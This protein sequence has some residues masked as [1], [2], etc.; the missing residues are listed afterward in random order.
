MPEYL[1]TFNIDADGFEAVGGVT[2]S[3]VIVWV[4]FI[5]LPQSSVTLYVLVITSGQVLPSET[6]ETKATTG[7]TVQLSKASVT[8]VIS[9]AGISA[10]HSTCIADGFEA[11]GGVTSSTVIVWVTFIVLPQSSVTLYVLVITSGQVLPSETSETKATTGLTVQLSKAS[12]TAVMSDAGIS[13][14]H[15]TAI[16][17]GFEA[18]GGVTSSTVIVWVTFIVLPQSSVTLY[19]L[20]ITSGQVLPSETSETNATT[21][22]TVQL[23]KASVTAVMSDAGISAVH[24]T[25]IADGFEAVGGVTSSTVIVWVTFIVLPQSSV[26]LYVLVITSGQVLPSE[27]SETN[28][29]T[30]LTVQLSKASVTAVM[31]DAGISAVHS[32]AIADGFEA[33]GGVTSSTVI[34]WVTFIVLP[35]SSVTLYVLVITSGQVLPSETS[36][37]NATTGLTVQL[38]KASVTAVMSDAGISA[39]HSTAIADGF[40]AVGGVTS[41]TVIV[42]VTFIVLPQSSVTLYVLVITSGQV[43]PSETS[44]TNATTGLTVQ[45]SKASVTA[46]MSDAGISA[47]HSTAIADGF[48]AVG[49][50]TSS[51]VIVW[52]TFI[53]LPQSS[54]TLYVL[55]ITSG[56]VLP[57][58]TSETNATTGLTVQLSKA[59][60]TAVISDARNISGT[61]NSNS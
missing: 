31:S 50:V 29:T 48:E 25:A 27:T 10:V 32:T 6:S 37:T 28:A 55:V 16:A 30:G 47:V 7:L 49:G 54:V 40:E 56:Q 34:V 2:S 39:V 57:S 42:W 15:S 59:S 41:S 21:G 53:V 44:E 43:L 1:R 33:V 14:V 58:E 19:V 20:V 17:D 11:V 35:Q 23:S 4:T 24:S 22:L 60:V 18:V 45:L 5:V 61:F 9:D 51:T 8:A 36:E 12:V 46:V 3:T 26:T 38:S 13:A 52:V